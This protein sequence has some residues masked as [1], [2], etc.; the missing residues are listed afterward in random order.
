MSAEEWE[1]RAGGGHGRHTRERQTHRRDT[2]G[3]FQCAAAVSTSWR[4][5]C[6]CCTIAAR[7]WNILLVDLLGKLG[8]GDGRAPV[9]TPVEEAFGLHVLR[10]RPRRLELCITRDRQGAMLQN[11]F[12]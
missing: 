2:A 3:H 10:F 8:I 11:M 9:E 12:M 7:R 1:V 6:D 5:P 4:L